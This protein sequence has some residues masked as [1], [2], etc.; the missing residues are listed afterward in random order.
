MVHALTAREGIIRWALS[1]HGRF[2]K[3]IA[4]AKRSYPRLPI[5][6]LRSQRE[7]DNWLLSL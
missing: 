3:K 2:P 5:V 7:V 4:S 6:Q 1:T